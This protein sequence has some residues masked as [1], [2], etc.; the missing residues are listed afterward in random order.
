MRNDRALGTGKSDN[1]K[2]PKLGTLSSRTTRTWATFYGSKNLPYFGFGNLATLVETQLYLG[3]N[4]IKKAGNKGLV[5]NTSDR[6]WR[7]P[8]EMV[9]DL[10]GVK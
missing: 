3:A 2:N 5:L 1:N 10:A 7:M 8:S 9:T 4:I 6:K